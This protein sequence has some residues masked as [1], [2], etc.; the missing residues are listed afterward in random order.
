MRFSVHLGFSILL[1][2]LLFP[3]FGWNSLLILAGGIMADA[4]HYIYYAFKFKKFNPFECNKYF[5]ED[6]KKSGYHE[7]DG[8]VLVF[9]TLEFLIIMIVLSLYSKS[10]LILT[11]G[12]LSHYLLDFIWFKFF[13]KR[14][15]L[16][17]SIVWWMIK[18]KFKKFK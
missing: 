15:V 7:F 9:H 4:D 1:A 10:V 18:A 3:I 6:G 17:Y 16:N 14:F 11:I 13:L 2:A 8:L 12:I 5:T